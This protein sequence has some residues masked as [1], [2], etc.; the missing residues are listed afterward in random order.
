MRPCTAL[1]LST[2]TATAVG[3][4]S[5]RANSS[6]FFGI[7]SSAWL[8]R[9]VT[10]APGRARLAMSFWPTGSATAAMM[11][12]VDVADVPKTCIAARVV[13]VQV[14]MTASSF[15]AARSR[16]ISGTCWTRPWA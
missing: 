16:A 14:A 2:S 5:T 3:L 15:S 4:P 11:I 10:L 8:D 9:P 7:R 6:S 12:G 1:L 13:G